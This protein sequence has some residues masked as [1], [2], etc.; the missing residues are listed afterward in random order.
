M[1][2]MSTLKQL[3]DA[4]EAGKMDNP[5]LDPPDVVPV[6]NKEKESENGKYCS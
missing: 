3:I 5:K 6:G 4:Q 2:D 1:K